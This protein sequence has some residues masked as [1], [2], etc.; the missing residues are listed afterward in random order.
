MYKNNKETSQFIKGPADKFGNSRIVNTSQ[1]SNITFRNEST[2]EEEYYKIIFNF[3]TGVSLKNDYDKIIPQYVYFVYDNSKEYFE[4]LAKLNKLID[5]K[6][7]LAP[8]NV[9]GNVNMII[10]P[11]YISFMAEDPR[12]NR[13]IVNMSCG[14][15]FYDNNQ[16]VTSDFIYLDYPTIEDMRQEQ[17]YIDGVL[18]EFV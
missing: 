7:W 12:K 9:Q 6:G 18:A 5:G 3:N 17:T 10:N 14:V 13:I 2:P 15:S 1:V 11:E 16:R 4:M 8:K